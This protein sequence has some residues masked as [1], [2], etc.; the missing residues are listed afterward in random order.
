MAPVRADRGHVEVQIYA[1]VISTSVKNYMYYN[2]F[3][4]YI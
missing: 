1:E 2:H 4:P 3:K